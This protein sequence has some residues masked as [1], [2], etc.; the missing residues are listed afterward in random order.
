M[1]GDQ[2]LHGPTTP[3]EATVPY[4][5]TVQ[6]VACGGGHT[7]ALSTD[8]RVLSC[9]K[10]LY[11]RLGHGGTADEEM[12]RIIE[13]L[14]PY[15]VTSVSCGLWNSCCLTDEGVVLVWGKQSTLPVVSK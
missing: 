9:G 3:V 5:V 7:L 13:A 1:W 10:G 8:G 6:K 11:G 14:L 15:R 4:D 12:F 2:L